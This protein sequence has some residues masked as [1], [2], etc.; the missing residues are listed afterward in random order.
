MQQK[1]GGKGSSLYRAGSDAVG[2]CDARLQKYS[3]RRDHW[4]S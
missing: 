4:G 2:K 3:I 1:K